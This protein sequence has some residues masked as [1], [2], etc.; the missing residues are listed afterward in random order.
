MV[1][2]IM[3]TNFPSGMLTN[4]TTDRRQRFEGTI[5]IWVDESEQSVY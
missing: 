5:T 1:R 2:N 4:I 3:G